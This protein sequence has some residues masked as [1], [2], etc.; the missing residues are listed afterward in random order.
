[1]WDAYEFDEFLIS[2]SR[3][4]D[5]PTP[6]TEFH[7]F[8]HKLDVDESHGLSHKEIWGNVDK[9]IRKNNFEGDELSH[10]HIVNIK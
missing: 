3:T 9:M 1:M 6:E 7:D 5:D 2:G 4:M 8:M 10:L